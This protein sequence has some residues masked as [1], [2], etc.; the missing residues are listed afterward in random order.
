MT[1]VRSPIIRKLPSGR[2]ASRSS[3]LYSVSGD[4]GGAGSG[5]G[6]T[7]RTAS[8]TARTWSGVVPQQPPSR[9]TKPLVANSRRSAAVSAGR[10]SYSPNAFGR[11]A[12]G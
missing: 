1:F 8:A 7:S 11:P 10:S 12:L 6:A 2:T 4:A 9:F 5:R 3:P